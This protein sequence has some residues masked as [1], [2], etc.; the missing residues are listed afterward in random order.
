MADKR[1]DRVAE[2]KERME[3]SA[4]NMGHYKKNFKNLDDKV[5]FFVNKEAAGELKPFMKPRF[6]E[7][8]KTLARL[9]EL[10]GE[11]YA[12]SL[13]VKPKPAAAATIAKLKTA[14]ASAAKPKPA[15]AKPKTA[16]ST[17]TLS[18]TRRRS[19][20]NRPVL[21][22]NGKPLTIRSRRKRTVGTVN[23]K[24]RS[25]RATRNVAINEFMETAFSDTQKKVPE[26][27]NPFTG[28]KYDKTESPMEDIEKAYMILRRIR[29]NTISRAR[30]LRT[31]ASKNRSKTVSNKNKFLP[32]LNA[33]PEGNEGINGSGPIAFAT[34]PSSNGSSSSSSSSNSSNSNSPVSLSG[35]SN[36][37]GVNRSEA[38]NTGVSPSGL[39]NV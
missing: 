10:H 15:S 30:V 24:P 27:Y 38:N 36:T 4:Y 12:R 1:K 14:A 13:A 25:L 20:S 16:A 7:A 8:E 17:N 22:N 39:R 28:V 9:K 21:G 19:P 35:L 26:L 31:R 29:T 23:S 2:I 3:S 33:V 11:G 32:V 37:A 18:S 5:A 34:V 6:E